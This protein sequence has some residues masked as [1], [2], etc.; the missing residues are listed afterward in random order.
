[1]VKA[2]I[3]LYNDLFAFRDPDVHNELSVKAGDGC[4]HDT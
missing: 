2:K 4:R 3:N 1:M